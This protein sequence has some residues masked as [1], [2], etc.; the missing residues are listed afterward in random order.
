MTRNTLRMGLTEITEEVK[1]W[2]QKIKIF[3]RANVGLGHHKS[4]SAVGHN[5]ALE[6]MTCRQLS[7]KVRYSI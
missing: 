2:L 7:L 4:L 5:D 3:L 1:I 6:R